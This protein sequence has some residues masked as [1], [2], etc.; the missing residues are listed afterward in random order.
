MC[1]NKHTDSDLNLAVPC[2]RYSVAFVNRPDLLWPLTPHQVAP[3]SMWTLL[4]ICPC[5]SCWHC[6]FCHLKHFHILTFFD[7]WSLIGRSHKEVTV[8]TFASL[9]MY[10]TLTL[11][12]L[13]FKVISFFD[14][15]WPLTPCAQAKK[16]PVCAQGG[17]RYLAPLLKVFSL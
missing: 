15:L 16:N 11:L 13:L 12:F 8:D 2:R 1:D 10:N 4:H 17:S 5:L 7:L 3:R 14:L 9:S 6:Y